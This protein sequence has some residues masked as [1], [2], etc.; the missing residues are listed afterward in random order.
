[1]IQEVFP[2]GLI[3]Q[4]GRLQ[5][6]DQIIE[7]EGS[8]MT[9]ASHHQVCTA[10]RKTSPVLR[11]GIYRERVEA[12]KNSCTSPTEKGTDPS[13]PIN[14]PHTPL[15]TSSSSPKNEPQ[16]HSDS[17]HQNCGQNNANITPRDS[18]KQDVQGIFCVCLFVFF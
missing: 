14:V 7:I 13:S 3:A 18:P 17:E 4:D 12:Y 15:T 16:R 10:L 9:N 1:M 2:D 6:G 8:D 11:L 5:A